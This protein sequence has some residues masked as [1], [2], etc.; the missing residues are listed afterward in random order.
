MIQIDDIRHVD[1]PPRLSGHQNI[2]VRFPTQ[3]LHN[4][5]RIFFRSARWA[6]HTSRALSLSG[7]LLR[8]S[9]WLRGLSISSPPVAFA[10]ERS[11]VLRMRVPQRGTLKPSDRSVASPTRWSRPSLQTSPTRYGL[12]TL[13]LRSPRFVAAA[14]APRSAIS[15]ANENGRGSPS[16]SS[17]P[18][19]CAVTPCE[20]SR[21]FPGGNRRPF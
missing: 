21:S 12:T 6:T 3:K 15:A 13:R 17:L 2:S 4:R 14:F 10:W 19:S 16:R 18:R 20:T 5:G 8:F 9:T 7:T 11:W 1:D